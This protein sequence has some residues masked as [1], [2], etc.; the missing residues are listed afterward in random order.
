[1]VATLQEIKTALGTDEKLFDPIEIGS[2]FKAVQIPTK[3]GH[4]YAHLKQFQKQEDWDRVVAKIRG[5]NG[6]FV[7]MKTFEIPLVSDFK[8]ADRLDG[9]PQTGPRE[10]VQQ[11]EK[12]VEEQ[13]NV[14]ELVPLKLISLDPKLIRESVDEEYVAGLAQSIRV[15]GII[16]PFVVRPRS[17][18]SVGYLVVAGEQRYRAAEK[19]GLI[20]VP[21]S[22]RKLNDRE[23]F[24][25][26]LMENIQRKDLPAIEIARRIKTMMTEWVSVYGTQEAVG[27]VFGKSN[28]WVSKHLAILELEAQGFSAPK[29][30]ELT[31]EQAQELRAAPAEKR[32]EILRDIR[33]TGEIPSSREIKAQ[34]KPS[35]ISSATP[36]A[37]PSQEAALVPPC[38]DCAKN[39]N[40]GGLHFIMAADGSKYECDRFE[41]KGEKESERNRDTGPAEEP[42]AEATKSPA[43]RQ[44]T[45]ESVTVLDTW[46]TRFEAWCP[47][48]ILDDIDGFIKSGGD[49]SKREF[50]PYYLDAIYDAALGA[51]SGPRNILEEADLRQSNA[52]DEKEGT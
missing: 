44:T 6:K 5:V 9:A 25:T 18:G 21:V 16:Q 47:K 34:G 27:R 28:V 10:I 8:T 11:P 20:M 52:R 41:A 22:I 29:I 51:G 48:A 17:D 31:P 14:A 45:T 30:G 2:S 26:S 49:Q 15:R 24:E 38:G 13:P 42:P 43:P 23:A 40:C 7:G 19:A 39:P 32:E 36:S 33:A 3:E 4:A 50:V 1:L 37:T 46:R 12:R 35:S